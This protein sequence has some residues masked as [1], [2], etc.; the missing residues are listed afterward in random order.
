MINKA[1]KNFDLK[2]S[3]FILLVVLAPLSKYPSLSLPLFNFPS[4]RIGLYQILA[5]LFVIAC[6]IEIVKR[7]GCRSD[8]KL[9]TIP[10]LL[11]LISLGFGFFGAINQS[12]YFLLA[13]SIGLL[14]LLIYSSYFYV[15]SYFLSKDLVRLIKIILIAS[16]IYGLA[17]F[18]QFILAGFTNQTMNVLCLN[19]TNAVFGFPRINFS[20]AEPQ[21]LASSLIPF[22]FISFFAYVKKSS[23]LSFWA[24]LLTGMAIGLT[25]SRGAYLAITLSLV[26]GLIIILVHFRHLIKRFIYALLI[27][28]FALSLSL[29]MLI[30]SASYAN[31][32]TPNISYITTQTIFEHL[33]LG[34]INL[35]DKTITIEVLSA[36]D[37]SDDFQPPGLIEASTNERLDAANLALDAWSNNL[38]NILVGVGAGNLGPYVVTNISSSAPENLTVYIFYVLL[39]SE[40]GLIGLLSFLFIFFYIFYLILTKIKK[41][42]ELI[43]LLT[44]NSAFF[45]QYFFFGS[46]I[47]VV[48]IWLWLGITLGVVSLTDNKLRK[49]LKTRV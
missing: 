41:Y 20:S 40:L 24:T 42:P 12:R 6:L 49:L 35:P 48:Y 36:N 22:F 16:I 27:T 17:I 30:A 34:I 4:Y 14:T 37:P 32:E 33:S 46:Y 15:K 2:K 39:L 7:R 25:F 43:V 45:I 5:S 21:F 11:I 9:I 28:L 19:C 29:L 18:I 44:I 47:N 13:S 26:F 3:L 23:L 8:N 10:L 38:K 1:L 31:K